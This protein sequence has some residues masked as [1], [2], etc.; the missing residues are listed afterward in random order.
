MD[1]LAAS[2]VETVVLAASWVSFLNSP[3]LQV[4]KQDY[5]NADVPLSAVS[6]NFRETVQRL[7]ATGKQVLVVYPG[8]RFDKPMADVMASSMLR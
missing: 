2:N 1:Y 3:Y 4:D 5:S 7:E 8:P 6:D